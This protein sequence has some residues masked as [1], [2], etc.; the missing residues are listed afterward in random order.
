MTANVIHPDEIT[1][2]G[3][4]FYLGEQKIAT[5][6]APPY[7][8]PFTANETAVYA[9]VVARAANDEAN[10]VVFFG[11]RSRETIDVTLQQVSPC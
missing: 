4:D 11:D 8:T 10:D 2:Q 3:V 7:T 1:V 5:D 6:T 9:R